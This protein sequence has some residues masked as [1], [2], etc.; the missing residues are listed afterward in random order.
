ML[1]IVA[2]T[3]SMPHLLQSLEN[4]GERWYTNIY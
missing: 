3:W 2:K 4:P 1:K